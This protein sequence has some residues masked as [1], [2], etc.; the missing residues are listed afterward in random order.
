MRLKELL[1]FIVMDILF[2][3]GTVIVVLIPIIR[4]VNNIKN[5][6]RWYD[7]MDNSGE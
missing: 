4:A 3:I 6:R 5:G 1:N 2:I 7:G